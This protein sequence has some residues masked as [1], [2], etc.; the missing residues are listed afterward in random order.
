MR[1]E[2][3]PMELS[4]EWTAA[5]EVQERF[6]ERQFPSAGA[7]DVSACCRQVRELGGDFYDF[8][9]LSGNRL[10][11]GIGDASGKGLA[12]ALM[13]AN[14]QSSLRTASLFAED[15]PARAIQAVNHQ[16]HGSSLENRF[17]TLFYGIFDPRSRVLRYVNAG[18]VP[19]MVVGPDGSVRWLE[20]GGAPVG[21]F[22]DWDYEEGSAQLDPGDVV[23]ACTDGVTEAVSPIGKDWGLNGLQRAVARHGGACAE[24]LVDSV[25][26]GMDEFTRRK[27][28]DDATVMVLRVR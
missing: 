23:V 27:Q 28:A 16:L 7:L 19:P 10:A 8:H 13:I 3:L 24:N 20:C 5:R 22:P 15:N 12:A 1:C 6:M 26:H 17:A 21:L 14:V 4:S 2:T 25:F 9:P 11:L 18:H